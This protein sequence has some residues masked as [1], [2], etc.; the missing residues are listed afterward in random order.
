MPRHDRHSLVAHI[1]WL[2]SEL[3]LVEADPVPKRF[4]VQTNGLT[5]ELKNLQPQAINTPNAKP[6]QRFCSPP[7]AT[8]FTR[9]DAQGT[10]D[11]LAGFYNSRFV[12]VNIADAIRAEIDKCTDWLS[13]TGTRQPF[14]TLP[15]TQEPA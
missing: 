8:R 1:A 11:A 14:D 10:A 3:E 4:V 2:Q 5:V 7:L 6:M 12:A 9:L 15:I 13:E